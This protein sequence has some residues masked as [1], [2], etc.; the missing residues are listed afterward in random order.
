MPEYDQISDAVERRLALERQQLP[1]QFLFLEQQ[2]VGDDDGATDW[3]VRFHQHPNADIISLVTVSLS[4]LSGSGL[5]RSDGGN[6]TA[7]SGGLFLPAG[8]GLLYLYTLNDVR[9]FRI[10][11]NA[12]ETIFLTAAAY[13]RGGGR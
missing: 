1:S 11:A 8:G 7:A 9:F 3:L 13:R 2:T 12:G 6:I 4:P 10:Q 5:W